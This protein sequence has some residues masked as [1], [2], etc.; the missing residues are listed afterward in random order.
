MKQSIRFIAIETTYCSTA[1][2]SYRLRG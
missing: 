2:K 1:H